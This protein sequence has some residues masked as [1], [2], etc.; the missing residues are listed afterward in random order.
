MSPEM[1]LFVW[2]LA[3][4][5]LLGPVAPVC[6]CGQPLE[7]MVTSGHTL[8]SSC[9]TRHLSE[10]PSRQKRVETCGRTSPWM[11]SPTLQSVWWKVK[12]SL[13]VLSL[14]LPSHFH[15]VST[16]F[17]ISCPFSTVLIF[18]AFS[19]NFHLLPFPL[20]STFS[21]HQHPCSSAPF[22]YKLCGPW[23]RV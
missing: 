5:T 7:T 2:H 1:S 10:W 22:P 8:M 4:S 18:H 20:F 3:R 16:F 12:F 9:P 14:F 19:S 11:T 23:G 15:L 21:V 6:W 13:F 17:L